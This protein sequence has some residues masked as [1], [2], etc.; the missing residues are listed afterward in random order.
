M[1]LGELR[2]SFGTTYRLWYSLTI[3]IPGPDKL[4]G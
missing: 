1:Y 3:M 2:L 4:V